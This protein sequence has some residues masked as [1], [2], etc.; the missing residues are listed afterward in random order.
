[1]ST[2]TAVKSGPLSD[3]STFSG[4][5]STPPA[6]GDTVL[7]QGFSLYCD[8]NIA[9]SGIAIN[10][11]STTDG[12]LIVAPGRTVKLTSLTGTINVTGAADGD[13]EFKSSG[14]YHVG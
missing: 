8:Y 1:M 12:Y 2:F 9:S 13:I 7:I 10:D 3:P 4:S 6:S 5:P 11:T 14:S